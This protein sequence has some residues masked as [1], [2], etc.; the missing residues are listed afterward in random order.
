[1][2]SG[3]HRPA[4][5]IAALMVLVFLMPVDTAL[6]QGGPVPLGSRVRVETV[7]PPAHPSWIVGVL[8]TNSGTDITIVTAGGQRRR[9]LHSAISRMQRSGGQRSRALMGFTFGAIAGA[10]TGI[11]VHSAVCTGDSQSSCLNNGPRYLGLIGIGG[12]A[13]AFIGSMFREETWSDVSLG[14]EGRV[15]AGL[16]GLTIRF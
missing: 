15:R 6:A 7:P 13:G 2:L 11:V 8:E 1:M 12:L 16:T 14:W 10:F 5:E 4:A 9:I 3:F